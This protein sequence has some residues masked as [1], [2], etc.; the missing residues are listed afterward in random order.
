MATK[1]QIKRS[2][3]SGVA[4]TVGDIAPGELA[5]NLADKKL[6]TAN[7][8]ATFE[9]G[10][11]LTN[12]SVTGNLVVTSIVADGTVGTDGQ[13]L[14]SNGTVA[15]WSTV[16]TTSGS[17]SSVV[18]QQFTA[19]GT[20]N[21]FTISGGYIPN[22]IEVY[23]NGVK[24]LPNSEVIVSSGSTINF[25]SPPGNNYIVD[26]FGYK[27][28]N[29]VLLI[30]DTLTSNLTFTNSAVIIANGSFGANN[31]VLTSNGS[32]MYWSTALAD[33]VTS[34]TTGNG[35]I[36]GVITNT[37]TI[38][39]LA[40][41]GIIANS[42]GL[43]V[44][45]SYINTL[46]SNTAIYLSNSS[47]TLSNITFWIAGNSATA[48]SNATS[49]VD[50][51]L[52][53]NTDQLNS[54]ITLVQSQIT[55]NS[56]T[57]YSNAISYVDG[58][59]Y[60]NT[61]LFEANVAFLQ[62]EINAVY[63]N[64]LTAYN[65]ATAYVDNKYYANTSQLSANIAT[66]QLQITAN[67]DSA[68]SNAVLYV[69][70]KLYVN[71]S[72]LSSN[73]SNYALINSP[74]F[75]GNVGLPNVAISGT[76]TANGSTGTDGQ[77]LTSNG[78]AVYWSMPAGGF[79]NGQS[80]SVNNFVL[81]GS[82]T[83]NGSVG[84]N[85]QILISNGTTAYWSSLPE[86]NTST[87][88]S[89]QFTANGT[90][91][92]F[93]IVG[94]YIPSAIEVY[95]S[96]VKKI[97]GIDVDVTSGNTINFFTP[98]LN[99]Q[100]V[101]VFGYK[102]V[103]IITTEGTVTSVNSGVGLS[104]GIIT[105]TGT[106]SVLANNGI[107]ANSSGTFVDDTYI[108][109]LNSNTANYLSNTSGTLSNI[110]AWITGNSDIA[111][112]NAVSYI[113]NKLYANTLQLSANI[114]TVQ[115]QIT[116]NSVTAYTNAVSYIDNK[117]YAN[118]DQLNANI[119]L[120]QSQ[121]TANSAT[122]YSNAVSYVDDKLFVNT[123]QLSS[124]LSNYA[125]LTGAIF[126][127]Q[128]NATTINTTGSVSVG[129]SLA[130]TGNLTI[131]GNVNV[132]GA[133]NLSVVDNMIYLNANNT[134][135]NPDLGFAGNY[136][137]G[138]YQH[139]GLFR[140][141]SD[142]VWKVYDGYL[143]EPDASPFID[144][145][146]NSFNIAPFHAG[147]VNIGNSTV[148]GTI[149]STAFTGTA[150]NSTNFGG[151]SLSTIQGQIS[152]NAATAYSNA[153]TYASNATNITTGILP[154]AQAPTGTVNTSGSFTYTGTSIFNANVTVNSAFV[155]ANSTANVAFFVANGNVGIGNSTPGSK[156]VVSGSIV[157]TAGEVRTLVLTTQTTSYTLTSNDHGD[158]VSTNS[159]II[160]PASV[161]TA[162]QNITVYN[163][164]AANIT[165]NTTS[166]GVTCYLAGSA[167]V[168]S[169]TLAQRGLATIVCVAGN[170]FVIS[171]AG[172]T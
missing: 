37:G 145:S 84:T 140:D 94:G 29:S 53:A 50:N 122:A 30:A 141:A 82:F 42:T 67:S 98:P 12:L 97:P 85:G 93:T 35:L 133:N 172:L 32:G 18:S 69:D 56:A 125:L 51:K 109:T 134:I 64:T 66:V 164:S 40:N 13:V 142:G 23:V 70:G 131:G 104:G 59:M 88:I 83:A 91:N 44:N 158:I 100:T 75:T 27:S 20:A 168:S 126:T 136:N 170:T 36:G 92:S 163:N 14:T 129:G 25:I 101:D 118:T 149:N 90:A 137:D 22:A 103:G 10:S 138:T 127:G 31:Q 143:P 155:V 117:L 162:G 11:N 151:L 106:L 3:V 6:Y 33:A 15:Y 63:A 116:A 154:W 87:I 74:T 47:G 165:I 54:N 52:Y 43:F 45:S 41:T 5:V 4:P 38:S 48:Y 39:V 58:K 57:A 152:G 110:I 46:D 80:I 7:S 49:Y 114:A 147:Y 159:T 153:T 86:S 2:S 169:R 108:N 171:G 71:T 9:L 132:I 120:V 68:Y 121:I 107:I 160:V 96:G 128:I 123:S 81:T 72:Q 148:Y 112:S 16:S 8:T 105:S 89:T 157:D 102:S 113:D 28:V 1:F 17:S 61:F 130:L 146:N 111:Y 79:T 167:N 166:V 78:S 77:V 26:V 55:A 150:N 65:N 99:N 139:A 161:F 21:S 60:V 115:S 62:S 119:A 76:I 135:T 34:I 124:N 144:T 24:Q 73:L 19:N 156:L 95:V